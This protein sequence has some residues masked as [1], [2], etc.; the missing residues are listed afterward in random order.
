MP[1][2]GRFWIEPSGRV[3]R[4]ELS[5]SAADKVKATVTVIYG[6]QPKLD[7]WVPLSMRE[8]YE[9][10]SSDKVDGVA[11]YSDFVVPTVSVDVGEF[12]AALSAKRGGGGRP[13]R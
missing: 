10:G 3:D 7:V 9:D 13:P 4:T 2:S 6:A 11:T 8:H 12:K 1:A 5:L